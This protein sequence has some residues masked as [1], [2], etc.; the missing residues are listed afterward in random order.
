MTMAAHAARKVLPRILLVMLSPQ[1]VA[2]VDAC[3]S[4]KGCAAADPMQ[5]AVRMK[6]EFDDPL[7]ADA[8]LQL[9]LVCSPSPPPSLET[10]PVAFQ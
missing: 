1:G 3:G 8:E 7:P 6:R 10:R 2:M 4:P 9:T 5:V